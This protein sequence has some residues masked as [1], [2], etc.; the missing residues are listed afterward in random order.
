MKRVNID[1]LTIHGDKDQE[2]RSAV[3][4]SFREGKVKLLIGTDV[5]ARGIDIPD[6]A[7]VVNYDLPDE[8][9]NYVH[10]VG[11][12]G[13][14][15]NKGHAYSFCAEEE[16]ESL[17]EIQG[18]LDKEIAVMIIDDDEYADTLNIERDRTND[19]MSLI[20]EMEEF[21]Q[22]KKIKKRKKK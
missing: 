20:K 9:E 15:K 14:G 18:Y 3:L 2:E 22:K 10:R 7:I 11:R 16:Q 12:T 1:S 19:Y 17:D 6:I 4:K 8:A 13:R 21:E 5:T